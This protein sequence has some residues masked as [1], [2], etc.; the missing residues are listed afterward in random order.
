MIKF[1]VSRPPQ[2]RAAIDQG[3]KKLDWANDPMLKGYGM[4][5]NP[6]MLKTNAR[7]LEPPEPLFAKGAT[8][9]PNFSGRWDLRGKVFLLP[10]DRPLKSWGIVV[11][12]PQDRR[13]PVTKDQ[14]EQ[15]KKNFLNL[16]RGHGGIVENQNPP[17]V[18]GIVDDAADI[19]AA[20]LAAGNAAKL[21]PQM[22]LVILSNK[23]AEIYNR[24]KK[25]CDCRYGIMSQCVQASNV[26][27]N[28]PQYCS[29]VLMKFNCKLGGTTCQIK[30][31]RVPALTF[32]FVNTDSQQ[33][34][35]YFKEPTMIIGADVSHAAPGMVDMASMAAMTVSLDKSCSRY[36]AAVQSNGHRVE[37]ITSTNVKEMLT[38]LVKWWMANIGQGRPPKHLYYFRDGVSEGQ[39]AALLNQEVADIKNLMDEMGQGA[40]ANMVCTVTLL[41]SGTVADLI[42]SPRSLSLLLRSVIIFAS[43]LP[44]EWPA[45]RMAT[46]CLVPWWSTM[47][48]ILG[49]TTFIFART[50]LFR[51]LLVQLTIIC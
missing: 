18:G 10:N 22:L 28:Q 32:R 47:L 29:N 43:S 48:L 11:L 30:A 33:R 49:R 15:F 21:R 31:V 5:I 27:K 3:L 1:A 39:Y 9:K 24:V 17:I 20:F 7:I 25:S 36:G 38:P 37:M 34:T 16:Y 44:K 40:P 26:V 13:P 50:W 12:M 8:A 46:L 51:E 2:R 19:E 4:K 41:E 23:S 35:P 42:D 6:T 45:I 14:V